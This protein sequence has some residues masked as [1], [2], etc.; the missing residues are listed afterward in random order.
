MRNIKLIL[1]LVT[2]GLVKNSEAILRKANNYLLHDNA[3]VFTFI[4][5]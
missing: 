4:A 5:Y 3:N 1:G 2:I